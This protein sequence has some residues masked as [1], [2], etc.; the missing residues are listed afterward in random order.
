MSM[1]Q[2]Y[3]ARS[4]TSHEA[5][6]QTWGVQLDSMVVTACTAAHTAAATGSD[7]GPAAA[8][9]AVTTQNRPACVTAADCLLP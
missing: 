8:L 5:Q 4:Q 2:C 1:I 9:T 3:R 7:V 6:A